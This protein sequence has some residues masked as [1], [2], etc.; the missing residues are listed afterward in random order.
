MVDLG[1]PPS[2]MGE[3]WVTGSRKVRDM[4][5]VARGQEEEKEKAR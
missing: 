3:L 4:S 5:A 2:R 1:D